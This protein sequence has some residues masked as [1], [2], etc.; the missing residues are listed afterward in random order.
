MMSSRELE[1]SSGLAQEQMIKGTVITEDELKMSS[2]VA[3]ALYERGAYR[4]SFP[5]TVT[6]FCH[7]PRSWRILVE[8]LM[9][10][11]LPKL[12]KTALNRKRHIDICEQRRIMMYE[13]VCVR[14]LEK[15][16]QGELRSVAS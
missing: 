7:T 10:S 4:L 15:R 8:L 12:S 9:S 6:L 2:C 14:V 5:V 1:C 3:R 16:A 11:N 13:C